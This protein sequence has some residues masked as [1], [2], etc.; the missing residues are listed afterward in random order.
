M[1]F[2]GRF[3]PGEER[4]K[5]RRGGRLQMSNFLLTR[6]APRVLRDRQKPHMWF[7]LWEFA[8]FRSLQT[9]NSH[10][11]QVEIKATSLVGYCC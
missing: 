1:G 4:A 3:N 9:N 11:M 7:L 8:L 5:M 2:K 6:V 10:Q